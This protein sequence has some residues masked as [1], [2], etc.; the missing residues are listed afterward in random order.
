MLVFSG[1][2]NSS[3]AWAFDL[4]ATSAGQ[5]SIV[6]T[7]SEPNTPCNNSSRGYCRWG[8]YSATQIDPS[9]SGSA[10]GFNELIAANA[11]TMF[12]WNTRGA[13]VGGSAPSEPPVIQIKCAPDLNNNACGFSVGMDNLSIIAGAPY[14]Y[15]YGGGHAYIFKKQDQLPLWNQVAELSSPKQETLVSFGAAVTIKSGTAVVGAPCVHRFAETGDAFIFEETQNG[16]WSLAKQLGPLIDVD[17]PP[18]PGK[19]NGYSFGHS[20]ALSG[21]T[22]IVGE[23]E[24]AEIKIGSTLETGFAYVFERDGGGGWK[25]T[26]KLRPGGQEFNSHRFGYAVAISGD[27]ALVGAPIAIAPR[28][29]LPGRVFVFARSAQSSWSRTQ[30]L[31]PSDSAGGDFFGLSIAVDGGTAVILRADSWD[32]QGRDVISIAAYIFERDAGGTWRQTKKIGPLR[33]RVPIER[34]SASISGNTV[35]VG[36]QYYGSEGGAAYVFRRDAGGPN[37]WGQVARLPSPGGPGEQTFAGSVA[38]GE[39]RVVVGSAK[40]GESNKLRGWAYVFK[41]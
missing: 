28:P 31:L 30:E 34:P 32:N 26:Q 19:V 38:T 17:P 7:A 2:N 13:L 14:H 25:R 4:V 23:P 1:P 15:G 35:V 5:I 11:T 40:N 33:A 18:L 20:V 29:R 10:W 39:D 24:G 6:G 36:G 41:F 16:Q 22:V 9:N 12:D 27:T 21:T 37:N 8:D 3:S